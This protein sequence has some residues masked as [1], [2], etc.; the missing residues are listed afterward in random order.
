[1]KKLIAAVTTAGLLTLG[2]A[3]TAFA[4]GG[5]GSTN[6]ASAPT[7]QTAK[8]K[9]GHRIARRALRVAVKTAADTIGVSP[10]DLIVAVRGGQTVGEFA[11]SKGVDPK[12]VEDAIVKALDDRID[13]AVADGKLDATRGA[14]LKARVPTF[15]HRVVT[16]HP[17][18]FAKQQAP[19]ST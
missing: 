16:T 10:K 12:T 8:G 18:R 5:D 15:A 6:G 1:M 4:A 7:T 13:Q 14:K 2:L 17:K 11:T 9:V 19:T 3:G